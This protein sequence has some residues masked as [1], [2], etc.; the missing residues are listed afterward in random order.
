M[1]PLVSII[2]PCYNHRQ[3]ILDSI[4][5]ILN[6]TYQ[7]I[8][9]IVID[10]GSKDDSFEEI[11]KIESE[12][13]GRFIR[14]ECYTRE[15]KGLSATLNE[16]IKW[17]QG[18]YVSLIASDDI[19]FP[20][21]TSRQVEYLENTPVIGVFGAVAIIDA[22]GNAVTTRIS[23][24]SSFSFEDIILNK[25]DLPACTQMLRLSTLKDVNGYDE[26]IKVEDWYLWLKLTK[27]GER[28]D[29]IPEV[30]CGYR[31]HDSNFS[32]NHLAM[33]NDMKKIIQDY[34]LHF[35]YPLAEYKINRQ[36][37]KALFKTNKSFS[38]YLWRRVNNWF[39]Y[40]LLKLK[41]WK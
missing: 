33:H 32:H 5:S 17:C 11:K 41:I 31:V 19:M 30:F 34:K 35:L 38:G 37:A 2:I 1:Q 24:K 23:N 3:Y 7:S 26:R 13:R 16:A 10:D 29:Y 9:L 18:K 36:I 12:C 4:Q 25:H 21:K 15:N 6:Q 22:T 40:Y 8:E 20:E 39:R 14:F 27:D 28:L